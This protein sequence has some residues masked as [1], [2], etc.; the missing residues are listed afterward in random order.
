MKKRRRR[1]RSPP[2][3]SR[4]R[5]V[6]GRLPHSILALA[7]VTVGLTF[8]LA[9][10]GWAVDGKPLLAGRTNTETQKTTVVNTGTGPA[11]ELDAASGPD[12]SVSS[13]ATV[14]NLSAA[15]LD[16]KKAEHFATQNGLDNEVASRTAA[17]TTLQN[18]INAETRARGNADNQIRSDLKDPGTINQPINPVD[19]TKLKG[20]PAGFADG[21]DAVGS[22]G[23]GDNVVVER[24]E[25]P[26]PPS[27]SITTNSEVMFETAAFEILA[28]CKAT[29]GL[30]DPPPPPAPG[31]PPP[32]PQPISTP[33]PSLYVVAKEPNVL[34]WVNRYVGTDTLDSQVHLL[35]SGQRTIVA[36]RDDGGPDP[37]GY[38]SYFV[39]APSGF[40]GG[41]G[42]ATFEFDGTPPT[43]IPGD[44]CRFSATGLGKEVTP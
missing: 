32:A 21:E 1:R 40:L 6:A 31:Q 14:A 37:V 35:G 42:T 15:M 11:L 38:G 23:A 39:D 27:G 12:L 22:S 17:D 10:V 33:I 20:V 5:R 4:Y 44:T 13:T 34:V 3:V 2:K 36:G 26:K 16:G 25:L 30:E 24:R 7:V 19:W 28:E 8:G 43:A 18:N 29:E 41:D 9:S